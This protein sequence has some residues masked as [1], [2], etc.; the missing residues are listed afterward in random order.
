MSS[1]LSSSGTT[2]TSSATYNPP[3]TATTLATAF[4]QPLQ[5]QVANEQAA[6]TAQSTAY[7]TLQS[8]LTAFDTAVTGLSAGT[9]VNSFTSTVSN[10]A[11][12]TATASATATAG[13]YSFFV[14]QLA[15][16]QQTAYASVPSFAASGAGTLKIEIGTGSTATSFNVDLSKANTG[17]GSTVSATELAAA[18]NGATGNNGA[19]VASVVTVGSQTDLVVTAGNTGIANKLT[20]D[21]TNV[22]DTALAASLGS[23]TILTHAQDA[24]VFLGG[25]GG[26]ELTQASNTFTSIAGVSVDFTQA[27][28]TGDAPVTLT[29]ASDA[30]TTAANVQTFV[31]AYNTVQTALSALTNDGSATSGAAPGE[32]ANDS[33]VLNLES[34]LNQ[35]IRQDF[36]GQSLVDIGVSADQY[37]TLSLDQTKLTAALTANPSA[38]SNV[39]GSAGGYTA[40]TGLLGGIDTY[41]QSWTTA[42]SGAIAVR[43]AGVQ[44]T[45]TSLT[46]SSA[47]LTIQYNDLYQKYLLEFTNLQTL[48]SQLA[49]SETLFASSTTS[50]S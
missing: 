49:Q 50:S 16:A 15:T 14:Q 33:G 9:G 40:N 31:T 28:N 12:A 8:A 24:Q 11:I 26:L 1:V 23:G 36:N 38:L 25:A 34:K 48:Q 32:L 46:A 10:P 30:S 19:A 22:G 29:V 6:A 2:S 37:G 47:Q 41:L 5:T 43:Q 18:I 35:F 44:A 45:Q 42:G 21:T 3:T 7:T 4:M 39:F 27:Q 17:G 13:T 20:L